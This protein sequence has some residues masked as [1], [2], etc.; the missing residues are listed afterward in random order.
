MSTEETQ[1]E[2]KE[3]KE[4]VEY[5]NYS[6]CFKKGQIKKRHQELYVFHN[7]KIPGIYNITKTTS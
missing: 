3:I 5:Q 2:L 6:L 1:S 4:F 7:K